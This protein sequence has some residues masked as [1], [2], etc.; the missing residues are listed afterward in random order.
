MRTHV[1]FRS[2]KFLPCQGEEEQVN[3][4]R[5]GKRLAEYLSRGLR[6]EGIDTGEILAEDWG[7]CIPLPNDA[8]RMWI[9]CGNYPE[10]PDGFLVFIEPSKRMIRRFLKKIDTT[11]EVAKVAA[12]LDRI[13]NTDPEIRSVRWWR[14]NEE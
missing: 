12:A 10:Y 1:E 8:F 11:T 14:E 4:G 3:P 9:G 7:W 6:A 13:L 5:W 2:D